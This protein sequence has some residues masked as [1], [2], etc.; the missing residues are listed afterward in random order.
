MNFNVKILDR[1]KL[2]CRRIE[3]MGSD[4]RNEVT[5]GDDTVGITKL[6]DG[7]TTRMER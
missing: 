1:G 7:F 5:K 6:V 3:L 2:W 4:F